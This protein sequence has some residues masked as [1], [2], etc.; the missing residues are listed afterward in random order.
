MTLQAQGGGRQRWRRCITGRGDVARRRRL[1][2]V[3][4]D[5]CAALGGVG[6]FKGADVDTV[7]LSGWTA[8]LVED[9]L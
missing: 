9:L 6:G 4:I 7:S 8:G 1:V 3:L 5:D 2:N